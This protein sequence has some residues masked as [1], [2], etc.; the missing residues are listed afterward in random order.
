MNKTPPSISDIIMPIFKFAFI[1][2]FMLG[3]ASIFAGIGYGIFTYATTELSFLSSMYAGLIL[4][5]KGAGLTAVISFIAFMA[6]WKKHQI[7]FEKCKKR[8]SKDCTQLGFF[9]F[10]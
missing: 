8:G 6:F 4:F 7:D 1:F 2:S 9:N 3:F 5:L 10:A